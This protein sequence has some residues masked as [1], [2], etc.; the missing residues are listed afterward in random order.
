[1][2]WGSSGAIENKKQVNLG[3]C[4]KCNTG[5]LNLHAYL[6]IGGTNV[7]LCDN[8][9]CNYKICINCGEL[10]EPRDYNNKAG[11]FC[12]ACEKQKEKN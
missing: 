4:P 5:Q 6:S 2:P 3:I 1:M 8:W 10:V 12:P 7:A 11:Y 9:E